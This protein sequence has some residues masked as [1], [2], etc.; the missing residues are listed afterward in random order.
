ML[1]W[2]FAQFV[3]LTQVNAEQEKHRDREI[4]EKTERTENCDEEGAGT[5]ETK[6][7]DSE[8][9]GIIYFNLHPYFMN[10]SWYAVGKCAYKILGM[11]E[12][13]S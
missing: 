12:W 6:G 5:A 1:P 8:R 4:R 3:L 7:R 9:K 13:N 11:F 2:Q 10:P